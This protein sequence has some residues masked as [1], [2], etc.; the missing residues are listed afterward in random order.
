MK[1]ELFG[2]LGVVVE[3]ICG[4]VDFEDLGDL[5]QAY[6]ANDRQVMTV[7]TIPNWHL[8]EAREAGEMPADLYIRT[9]NGKVAVHKED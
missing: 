5:D 2:R 4:E 7:S 1:K 8:R 3:S 6:S 9:H